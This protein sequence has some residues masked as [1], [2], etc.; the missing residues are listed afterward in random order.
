M[1]LLSFTMEGD[2][3]VWF[4]K[5]VHSKKNQITCWLQWKLHLYYFEKSPI[6]IYIMNYL[7]IFF[8]DFSWNWY[9]TNLES[10]HYVIKILCHTRNTCW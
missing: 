8:L 10:F 1:H 3:K 2:L 4:F 9:P 5:S 7:F 6:V